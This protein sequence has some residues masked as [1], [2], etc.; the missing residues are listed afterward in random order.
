MPFIYNI[1]NPKKLSAIQIYNFSL[2]KIYGEEHQKNNLY[3]KA[4]GGDDEFVKAGSATKTSV[5]HA[6][7]LR[8]LFNPFKLI[9]F[10]FILLADFTDR[11]C[12][13]GAGN[14]EY[15]FFRSMLRGLVNIVFGLP[16]AIIRQFTSP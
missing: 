10:L 16:I 5:K 9:E 6:L 15:G 11:A 1:R 14:D 4:V 8:K 2:V 12:Q 7:A 3:I 13:I